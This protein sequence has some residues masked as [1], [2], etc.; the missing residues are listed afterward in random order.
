MDAVKNV[1]GSAQEH[2][3]EQ[4]KHMYDQLPEEKKQKQTYTEWVKEAY[5]DK[6]E[7]WMPWIEDQY[8]KWFGKDNKAS[9][10]TKGKPYISEEQR[11]HLS[12]VFWID[13]LD[14]SKVTGI[15]QVD[16]LQDDVNNLVGNQVGKDG[17]LRPVGDMA[18]K[19]G[20]NRAERGGKDESGS[21]GGPA[22]SVTDP[23][24]KNA[25][26]AGQSVAGGAQAAGNTATE[27]VK[28]AGGYVGGLFGGDGEKKWRI[29][30]LTIMGLHDQMTCAN[31]VYLGFFQYSNFMFR[32]N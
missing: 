24:M 13:T 1:G 29:T 19:E 31:R 8:L 6:Y 4:K 17:L 7:T 10:A 18:S 2:T 20:I 15:S 3:E 16:K 22:S 23:V 32:A 26:G 30:N 28:S 25:Q 21:Y 9:Y 11:R 27:G 12:N 14:K 5:A